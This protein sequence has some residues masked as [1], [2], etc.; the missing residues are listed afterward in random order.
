LARKKNTDPGQR[1]KY[2]E[3][4]V[5]EFLTA[6]GDAYA[7]FDWE[8]KYDARSAGGRFPS[9]VADY[10]F[11]TAFAH[12]V[13][14]AKEIDHDSRLPAGKLSQIP[15]LFKRQLAGGVVVVLVL[16]TTV[17]RWRMVPFNWLCAR[18]SQP[19]WDLSEFP[20]YAR[21]DDIPSLL[22]TLLHRPK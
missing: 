16:H 12:G 6:L 21:L 1:G 13:I 22:P 4:K 19:S 9:Q 3:K 11:Y 15:R 17:D 8:R 7:D 5:K 20:T 10:G 18:R 14:E 2:A